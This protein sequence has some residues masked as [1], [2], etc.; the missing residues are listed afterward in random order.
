MRRVNTVR[1]AGPIMGHMPSSKPPP[2]DPA[3]ADREFLLAYEKLHSEWLVAEGA[4]RAA[5]Q[6]AEG[7]GADAA[8]AEHAKALRDAAQAKLGELLRMVRDKPL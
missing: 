7:G 8:Q 4:A 6:A 1:A 5:E 2:P 3:W